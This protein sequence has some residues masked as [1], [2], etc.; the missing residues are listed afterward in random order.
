METNYKFKELNEFKVAHPDLYQQLYRM[1]KLTEL[2]EDMNWP[3]RMFG[4]AS[5]QEHHDFI[6]KTN[7]NNPTKYYKIYK[8][9][10]LKLHS[11]PWIKFGYKNSIDFFDTI[12]G[13][14]EEFASEQEHRDFIIK[15]NSNTSTKYYKIY[16]TSELKLYSVPHK[17]FGYDSGKLFFDSIFNYRC[18]SYATELEHIKFILENDSR[19]GKKYQKVYKLSNLKLHPKPWQ[20]FKYKSEKL[21]FESIFGKKDEYASEQ[22]HRDFIIKTNSNSVN[23]YKKAYKSSNLKLYSSPSR[24]FGYNSEKS[25]FESI[26]GK[27]EEF[28]SEQEHRDFIIKNNAKNSAIYKNIYKSSN[29]KLNSKPWRFFK[30]N[31]EKLFFESIFGKKDEFASEQEHRDFIIKTN[32]NSFKKYYKIYKTCELRLYSNP[33]KAFG[34]PNSID[35]FNNIFPDR[36]KL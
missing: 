32:S 5:E 25:F 15:T 35:Y 27:K 29:L 20:F 6:I 19:S 18:I 23:K 4:F 13:E 22:E 7:S 36:N 17:A 9:S 16:K 33:H 24:A 21:F 8:N 12:F 28:A 31:S 14:K 3:H 34:Y 1:G 2:C 26:F 11:R 30:Y 10:K